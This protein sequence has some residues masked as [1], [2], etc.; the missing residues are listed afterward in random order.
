MAAFGGGDNQTG[1]SDLGRRCRRLRRHDRSLMPIL[2]LCHFAAEV[3]TN[4]PKIVLPTL[5][6][7]LLND[8]SRRS[9]LLLTAFSE[10]GERPGPRRSHS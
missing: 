6:W 5:T 1:G 2:V 8:T 4:M 9:F 10:K 3:S 7:M